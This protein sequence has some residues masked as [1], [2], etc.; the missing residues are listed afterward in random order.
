MYSRRN[1]I[2]TRALGSCLYHH[3]SLNLIEAVFVVV[4]TCNTR[5]IVTHFDVLLKLGTAKVDVTVFERGL[6]L[7][8]LGVAYL[9]GGC[10]RRRKHLHA[11]NVHFKLTRGDICVDCSLAARTDG[12]V[13][14][15]HVFRASRKRLVEHFSVG[16]VV[17]RELNYSRSVAKV[18]EYECT[19]VSLSLHPT[20]NAY[21]LAY[22]LL[23]DFGTVACSLVFICQKFCHFYYL[24]MSICLGANRICAVYRFLRKRHE[25]ELLF[26]NQYLFKLRLCS[27]MLRREYGTAILVRLD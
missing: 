23:G 12:S 5:N 18:D 19:E 8:L 3:G 20:H 2:V 11:L 1:E 25:I 17:K 4:F 21:L 27:R 14:A 10:L 26:F 6:V 7:D 9:K 15:K 13:N 24:S 16:L 22:H